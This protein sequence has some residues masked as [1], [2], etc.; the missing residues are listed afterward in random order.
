MTGRYDKL[1]KLILIGDSN[2]GKTSMV[3]RFVDDD[4]RENYILAVGVDFKIKTIIFKNKKIKIQIWDTAGQEKFRSIISSY[5]KQAHG[6]V[7]IFDLS[8]IKS[9]ENIKNIWLNSI[10][11]NGV[12][13]LPK[14]LI[15]NKCDI[16]DDR[17]YL[18]LISF[19]FVCLFVSSDHNRHLLSL[20]KGSGQTCCSRS[21]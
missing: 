13:L 5:Y 21:G 14:I 10:K 15:G 6:I 3:M 17:V 4:F 9:F 11:R 19:L 18:H 2:V 7:L 1:V 16:I 8:N 20:K 12:D